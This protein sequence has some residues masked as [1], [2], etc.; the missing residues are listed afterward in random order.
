MKKVPFEIGQFAIFFALSQCDI[1][2]F[3]TPLLI[4]AQLRGNFKKKIE[5]P[6]DF[7]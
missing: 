6:L 5:N 7:F 4:L 3:C 2:E 1:R